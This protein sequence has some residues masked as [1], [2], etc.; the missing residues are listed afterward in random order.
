MITSISVIVLNSFS[1]AISY[2]V[3]PYSSFTFLLTPFKSN[4]LVIFT[5]PPKAAK[6]IGVILIRS[7]GLSNLAPHAIRKRAEVSELKIS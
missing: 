3:L 1:T 6:C 7:S 2:A 5:L 4:F